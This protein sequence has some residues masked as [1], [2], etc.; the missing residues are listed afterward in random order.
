MK[1][2][3]AAILGACVAMLMTSGVVALA[4]AQSDKAALED[5]QAHPIEDE[6]I[7]TDEA[8]AAAMLG[9]ATDDEI[10]ARISA[11]IDAQHAHLAKIETR[12]L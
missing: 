3:V 1:N 11:L 5:V 9:D 4:T 8:Y 12:A 7:T 10:D 6:S 2:L